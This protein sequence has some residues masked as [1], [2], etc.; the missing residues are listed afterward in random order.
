MNQVSDILRKTTS[1]C[2]ECMEPIE[3][4]IFIDKEKNWVMMRKHCEKH[5]DFLDKISVDPDYYIWKNHYAE[6][7]DSEINTTAPI[8]SNLLPIKKGCPYDCGLCTDHQSAA[9]LMIID[10]TNRCNLNCPICFANAN[11]A[12]RIVEYTYEEV[13][14]IMKH[15][16]KQRPYHAAIAQFSGGEPTL[17]PRI[18][19]ILKA[20]KSLGFPHRM[21][22]TNGIKMAKS[23]DFCRQLKEADCGA[24]YFSYDGENPETYKKI[25]GMDLS[26]LKKKVIENCREVGLDGIMLVCTVAKGVN[27]NEI[28]HILEFARDNNDVIAGVVFQPVSLCG[29]ITLEDLMNLRYTS[30]DLTV[31]IKKITNGVVDKFYPLAASS[32]LTQL[33]TWFSDLPGWAIS[34]HNDCGFATLIPIGKDNEWQNLEDYVDVDELM[35]WT[36]SVWDMI[37]KREIPQPSKFFSSLRGPVEKL[38][39][40]KI[41]DALN[42]F[43]DKMTDIAYRNAMK[44]Y[45]IAG[46]AKYVKNFELKKLV[47]DPI[48]KS[49]TKLLLNPKLENSK[50]VLQNKL[51]FV[52][53][54]HFQDAYDLDVARLQKCV[55]HYGVIDP[56][57]PEHKQV[58]Q[59][60]FCTFN[61]IHREGIEKKWAETH[62]KP[63]EKTPDQHA[64]DIQ[65]L[66]DSISLKKNTDSIVE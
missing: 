35:K 12:G 66:T 23:L 11:H 31:E 17:H 5:G 43:N 34:A 36:N 1:I 63:L 22:N 24:I 59:I 55:V 38:G 33:L 9:N 39:F 65:T 60:P 51:M 27:D 48:Y 41:F 57:D 64:K 32:K 50:A 10:I 7:L 14:Q 16:I 46:A 2:P 19:D 58:L 54:M 28:K 30:S 8:N 49:V 25:R 53:S 4:E 15:F 61:T 6:D 20:A 52:G 45:Y 44:A 47:D 40:A 29:R 13:V 62:S 26:K 21:L 56:D 42:E 3:A 37:Q 18:I